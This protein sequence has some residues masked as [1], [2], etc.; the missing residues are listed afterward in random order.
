MTL[1]PSDFNPFLL[2]ASR[3]QQQQQQQQQRQ[4]TKAGKQQGR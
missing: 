1:Q 4:A 3:R 2:D